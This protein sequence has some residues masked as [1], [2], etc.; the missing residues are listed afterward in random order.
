[1]VEYYFSDINLATAEYLMR[2]ISMDPQGYDELHIYT[3]I[4][5]F[6]GR[7]PKKKK[8]KA[9]FCWINKTMK[10]KN[11]SRHRLTNKGIFRLLLWR[12]SPRNSWFR[13]NPTTIVW[14]WC[15]CWCPHLTK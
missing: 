9:M 8:I 12:T 7:Q 4:Y 3:W 2:F 13:A 1:M 6:L 11:T 10:R 14:C 5:L 15:W